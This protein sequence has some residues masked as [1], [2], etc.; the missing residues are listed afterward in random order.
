MSVSVRVRVFSFGSFGKSK[1]LE[2]TPYLSGSSVFFFSSTETEHHLNIFGR[3]Q[4]SDFQSEAAVERTLT[5][6]AAILVS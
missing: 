3:C 5:A 2:Y 1:R 6:T 4:T